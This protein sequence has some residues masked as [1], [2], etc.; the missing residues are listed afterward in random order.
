MQGQHSPLQELHLFHKRATKFHCK[1]DKYSCTRQESTVQFRPKLE[2]VPTLA[3]LERAKHALMPT[4]APP[5]CLGCAGRF[6][7]STVQYTHSSEHPFP[8][9]HPEGPLLTPLWQCQDSAA[10]TRCCLCKNPWISDT[11]E[12]A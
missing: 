9:G 8:Q 10:H 1:M 7:T 4:A 11:S 5:V 3:W 2:Y 12:S 6:R